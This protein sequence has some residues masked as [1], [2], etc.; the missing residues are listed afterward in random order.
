MHVAF[1]EWRTMNFVKNST[2]VVVYDK[3][4]SAIT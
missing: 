1:F 4:I 3:E 2:K